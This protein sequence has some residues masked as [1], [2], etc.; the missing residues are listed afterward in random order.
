MRRLWLLALGAL[1]P[2]AAAGAPRPAEL[3]LTV[4]SDIVV[5]RDN[6]AV[7][8]RLTGGR[9]VD[10]FPSWS[11]DGSRLVFVSNRDG[12]DELY[13]MR[14]DGS[15][16]RQLT[17]NK[18]VDTTPAWS[19]DG[20]S[21]AFASNQAGGEHKLYVVRA[22]GGTPRRLLGGRRTVFDIAP[23]WSPNGKLIAFASN[24]AGYFNSDI[25]VVGSDGRGLRRLTRT[26]GSESKPGDEGTP[27]WSPDGRS[28]AF[29][30]NRD[31]QQEIYVMSADGSGVRRL[32]RAPLRDDILPRWSPDGKTI[33]YTGARGPSSIYLVPA[34]GGA[35][36][37]LVAGS[38]A[39]W[40]P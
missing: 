1:I 9:A 19:P 12:D 39:A 22:S 15:Q 11:P 2:G 6:G 38:D 7:V 10:Y 23:A 21:I 17:H 31:L 25:W 35:S 27:A 30:T 3:A 18:A 4:A 8:R 28:I 24:R 20:R 33:A 37:R 40:R 26:A 14:A 16:L 34:A 13:V 32:T 5:I 29:A 36:R